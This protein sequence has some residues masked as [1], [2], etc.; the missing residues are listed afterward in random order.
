[1]NK[2][3]LVSFFMYA[4]LGCAETP[5][6]LNVPAADTPT[7]MYKNSAD[8]EMIVRN[9]YF[10]KQDSLTA[11]EKRFLKQLNKENE[12]IIWTDH[13]ERY[14]DSSSNII[15]SRLVFPDGFLSDSGYISFKLDAIGLLTNAQITYSFNRGQGAYGY[16]SIGGVSPGNYIHCYKSC[17]ISSCFELMYK[18]GV[19]VF[20]REN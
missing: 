16:G 8:N 10:H 19:K 1:M 4:I 7:K 13:V 9:H 3:Y 12:S 18:D 2:S 5:N 14:Y 20:E 6:K 17:G 11:D 15:F